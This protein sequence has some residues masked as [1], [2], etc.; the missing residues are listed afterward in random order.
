MKN[1]YEVKEQ[2]GKDGKCLR[3]ERAIGP[4]VVWAVVALAGLASGQLR[5]IPL[6]FGKYVEC[7]PAGFAD[8]L[9][10]FCGLVV[11]P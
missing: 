5:H 4:I 1:A 9:H 3:R 2:F 8:F 7:C 11:A 6:V 10:R